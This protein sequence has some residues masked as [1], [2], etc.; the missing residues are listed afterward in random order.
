MSLISRLF[1]KSRPAKPAAATREPEARAVP[2]AR[3]DT[4]AQAREEEQS[5]A[6]A[7]AAGDMATVGKWVVEG[8][9]TRLRQQAAR[10]IEEPQQLYELIRATRHGGDKSVYRILK[11]KRDALLA[12]ARA[13]EQRRAELESAAAA[14]AQHA[15]RA[16][17]AHYPATLR[18]LESR[19]QALAERAAP[20]LRHEVARRI[21]R[22]HA[23]IEDHQ[24]AADAEAERRRTDAAAAEQARHG[25]SLEAQARASAAAEEAERIAAERAAERAAAQAKHESDEAEIRSLIGLLRQ[26]QAALDHGGSAR[27]ARLRE[28]IAGKLPHAPALPAWFERQLQKIDA[29]LEELKDWKTFRV[30]PKRAE[31]LERMQSLVGADVS[32]EQLAQNIR[33]L[34]EEWRSLHRGAGDEPT[35]EWQRFEEVAERAYAP[36][37]EHFARQSEQ[38]RQNQ[39]HRE[40]LLERLA[41]FVAQQSGEQPDFQAIRQVAFEARQEWRKYAPVDAAVV[42]PL[43]E[44]FYALLQELRTPLEAEYARNVET[45]RGLIERAAALASLEDTREAIEES[46]RL[47]RAW[48]DVG[49][50]PRKLDNA[51]WEEFR[52][53]C[54]AVFQR[55]AQESA[56]HAAALDVN[57]ARATALCEELEAMAGDA[58]NDV[59]ASAQ[60]RRELQ[61]EFQAID[62]PRSAAR[63]LR[64]RFSRASEHLDEAQRLQRA[65]AARRGWNEA[66]A[67][68]SRIRELALAMAEGHGPEELATLRENAAAAVAAIAQP[69]RDARER[70]Q[71]RLE[72]ASSGAETVDR[73]AN[74]A[75]LR[76]LCIRAELLAGVESPPEDRELRRE[77]QMQRLV[78]SMGQG[79]RPA[80]ADLDELALDWLSVGPVD[81]TAHE[82]LVARF[83]HCREMMGR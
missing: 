17:D 31:L 37:R 51:L 26:A 19:W 48:K 58:G 40:A 74:E 30:A 23:V 14:I 39:V 57:V 42:K 77:Y 45:R 79:R 28:T 20:E 43:Q 65:A 75:T 46:K 62:L 9:S 72:Q 69:P 22:A 27:A 82:R 21:G 83:E 33:K 59:G 67:A 76:L 49:I 53:H 13:E 5:L 35:P 71:Q 16:Y 25:R 3:P 47:Q 11:T 10:S 68:A 29:R 32:P 66:F 8:S 55:G 78:E 38:R 41:A 6:R 70:L 15:D 81:P 63:E 1:G 61:S 24:K 50:V 4:S 7:L 44:R 73:T 60:R 54:D 80:S 2:V 52:R 18:Y 34:R 12:T 64:Q 56:A 36:C